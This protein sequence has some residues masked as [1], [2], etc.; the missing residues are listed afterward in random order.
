MSNGSRRVA[1][2]SSVVLLSA[3]LLQ[4][5]Q[6]PPPGRALPAAPSSDA[7]RALLDRYCV[8]CHNQRLRTAGLALDTL[9]P[10]N[11]VQDPRSWEQVVRRL[12]AG[13]MPPAGLPRPDRSPRKRL[14]RR[15]KPRS[16]VPAA[17]S[18]NP[19]RSTIHR[20]NR[21]E[22]VNAVRDL[23]AVEVDARSLLPADDAGEQGFDNIADVLSVSP[24][25][26]ERYMAAARR[27][28]APGGGTAGGRSRR[29]GLHR[30]AAVGA[31]R[32]DERR[33]AVR[34][35]RRRRGQASLPG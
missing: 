9:D 11:V 30:A 35:A 33:A 15:S 14:R 17:L 10:A 4:A 16:I 20:L 24:T 18:P 6:A 12:R 7:G 31:G 8:T 32:S 23:L 28:S 34:V 22:Y 3:A 26:L 25:L 1:I 5:T 13:T 21:A 2:W 19:G 29:A 27:I